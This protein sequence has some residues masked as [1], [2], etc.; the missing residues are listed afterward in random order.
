MDGCHAVSHQGALCQKLTASAAVGS[1]LTVARHAHDH[2]LL[3][4]SPPHW[5]LQAPCFALFIRFLGNCSFIIFSSF[6]CKRGKCCSLRLR[7]RQGGT[8]RRF[9]KALF[10][11]VVV[12]VFLFFFNGEAALPPDVRKQNCQVSTTEA[13]LHTCRVAEQQQ[14]PASTLSFMH[15]DLIVI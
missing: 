15:L 7:N 12:F 3:N 11:D 2:L 14:P 5:I 4:S 13:R 8:V 9:H 1:G 10:C 6:F